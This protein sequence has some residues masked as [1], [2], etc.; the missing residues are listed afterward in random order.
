MQTQTILLIVLAIAISLGLAYWQYLYKAKW[1]KLKGGLFFLRFLG[2]LTVLVLLINPKFVKQENYLEKPNLV[3]AVDNSRSV[4]LLKG[5]DAAI[6]FLEMLRS[7]NDLGNRFE[8][9]DYAFDASLAN[10]DSIGFDGNFTN[11]HE[12]IES[13]SRAHDQK[14]TALVLIT[15]GNQNLGFDYQYRPYDDNL[16]IFPV[17]VGDTTQYEDF[18]VERINL[19]RYAFLNNKF[20]LEASLVYEGRGPKSTVVRVSMD[21]QTVHRATVSFT[22]EANSHNLNVLL[23]AKDVGNKTIT[24]SMGEL[25]N[26]RNVANNVK[27]A[28][29]EVVD[30][31]TRVA[32]ISKVLHPDMAALKRAIESNEQRQVFFLKP[33]ASTS[34][35]DDYDVLI[36]YQPDN[37]F[38]KIFEYVENRGVGV[39]TI[40]GEKTDWNFLNGAQ[41]SYTKENFQQ[42]ED[43]FP[44]K[45]DAFPLFDISDF[46]AADLPPLK[47]DL[48]ELLIIRPHEP[49]FFQRIRGVDLPTPLL[50]LITEPRKE[51]LL[52]GNDIWKWRVETY[53]QNGSFESFDALMGRLLLNL[54]SNTS[55]KRLTLRYEP[56]YDGQSKAVISASYF[57]EAF[58]FDK[59]AS[60]TLT[61][62]N[63]ETQASRTFPLLLKGNRYEVDLSDLDAGTYAFTVK[64]SGSGLSESGQFTI[65]DFDLEAQFLSTNDDKLAQL[66]ESTGGSLL[67]EGQA[68]ELV[69]KLMADQRFVPI[70][71]GRQNIVSLIDFRILLGLLAL[72]LAAEWF[73]RKY[74]GLL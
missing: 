60:L 30:E 14:N 4:Q 24:V 6:S 1:S 71:K 18:R 16:T 32:L 46:S 23:Q 47:T 66:A 29:I 44:V 74:N 28:A 54:T 13:I 26:E 73:I 33:N 36:L 25:P 57:D 63:V 8:V 40:A 49:L 20:P 27:Q 10:N 15:D 2:L 53:R 11:I 65:L 22:P 7:Q 12:A 70:Q 50:T 17:A 43:V 56:I 67:Y 69:Q 48:G 55:K 31:R 51:V 5:T 38:S 21:G 52:L 41:V 64:V 68:A 72:T 39:F 34:T 61:V 37:S 35:L 19:N 9:F 58:V 42:T 62:R 45:N 59:N 3:L